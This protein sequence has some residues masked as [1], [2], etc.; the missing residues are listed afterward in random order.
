MSSILEKINIIRLEECTAITS[1][2][3]DDIDL[4]DFLHND[5]KNYLR[6]MLAVTY[7]AKIENE[8]AAYFCLSNDSLTRTTILTNEEKALWN[9][10]GRKIPN[11]KR[12]RTYPA[13]KIG[14]LAVAKEYSGF[15]I[16][17]QIIRSIAMI[18]INKQHHAGCRF[19]TVDAYQSALGFYQKNK[20][21]YLTTKDID[22][23]IRTMY[24]DL[25]T[26]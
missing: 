1:F 4:N 18:Y 8:I 14:R 6:S 5:A 21:Q 20:F 7:L 11:C 15:G 26:I 19:I 25:K 17:Q 2:D 9:K 16:G 12:R 24:F 23:D 3:C 22:D 13:V 10:V